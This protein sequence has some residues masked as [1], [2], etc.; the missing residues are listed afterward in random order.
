MK[1]VVIGSSN[2]DMVIK[3]PRLPRT[4]ETILGGK[5]YTAAGGRGANQAVSAARAGGDVTF[6][7]R[8]GNDMFGDRAIES[9]KTEGINTDHIVKDNDL[10]SG[11]AEIFIDDN[12][13]NLVAVASGANMNLS[14]Y[15]IINAKQAIMEADIILMQLEV[16]LKTL[17]YAAKL[18]EDAGKR[19]ILNPAPAMQLPI[20]LLK[21]ISVLTPNE[22]ES[23]LL[24][25]IRVEDEDSAEDAGRILLSKGVAKVIITLGSLGALVLDSSGSELV[26][27]FKINPVDTTA[28]GD[29][30][31]GALAVAIAESKNIF[32]AVKFANAA[33]ALSVARMGAQSSAPNRDEILKFM[34]ENFL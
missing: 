33:A 5:F 1:I 10:P 28:A 14:V 7:A 32:E 4:G 6:V 12:G 15:D 22:K 13:H 30:F 24:T 8:V 16:P 9:F 11:V 25:G 19:F 3:V 34:N 31:N 27:G 26:T 17:E 29:I 21:K 23:E 20:S 18:A 2:T